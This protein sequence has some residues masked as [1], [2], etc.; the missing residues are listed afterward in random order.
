VPTSEGILGNRNQLA[1][2]LLWLSLMCCVFEGAVRKWVVGDASIAARVAYLS[3]D[4]V[5]VAILGLGAGPRNPLTDIASPFLQVGLLLA[6]IGAMVN[7]AIQIDPIGA[8]LTLICLVILPAAAVMIG[9]LLPPDSLQRFAKWIAIL[10]LPLAMLGVLQF[11]SPPGSTLNRYSGTAEDASATAA[12]IAT[13][14]ATDR[15]AA[16]SVHVRATGTFS[17]ISGFSEFSVMAVWAGIVTFTL[18]R[19]PRLRWLGYAG[20]AAGVCCALSTVSRLP[21]LI[22]LGLLGV[23]VVAGGQF[24][25]KAQVAITIAGLVLAALLVTGKW[26]AAE[27]IVGSVYSRYQNSGNETLLGRAEYS[28]ITPLVESLSVAPFGAGLGTQQQASMTPNVAAIHGPESP[29]GRTI[30]EVGIIGLV[31]SI[32]T[33]GTVFGPLWAAYRMAIRGE[34]RT[35]LAVT[36][37]MLMSKALGGFQFNHVAAYFFWATSAAVLALGGGIQS[38]KIS[39]S[40][41]VRPQQC[42]E[43]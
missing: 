4:I 34:A 23:W 3:K 21:V 38:S 39:S 11:F 36:A 35:V 32:V 18:A 24:F 15:T 6:G 8:V 33:F 17:Y 2:R 28:F 43:F 26:Q 27:E 14:G 20:L 19:T 31:G 37:A 12:K 1:W 22:T 16:A 40:A 13:A 41:V 30:L 42:R 25:R 5:L 9:R 29:W 10:S 7:A